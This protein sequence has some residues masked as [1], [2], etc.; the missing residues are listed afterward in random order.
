MEFEILGVG[1]GFSRVGE[2]WM[3][4]GVYSRDGGR[5]VRFCRIILVHD[6]FLCFEIDI[7]DLV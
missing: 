1:L 6:L 5:G 7:L 3:G 2:W 4:D